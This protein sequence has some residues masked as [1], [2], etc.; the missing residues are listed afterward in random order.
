[1]LKQTGGFGKFLLVL[2][3][4]SGL[5]NVVGSIYALALNCQNIFHL[6]CIRI[7]RV[8]YTIAITAILIPVAF[9]VAANFMVSLSNFI[10]IIGI[11]SAAWAAVMAMEHLVI[12]KGNFENYE[13]GDWDIP[14]ALPTGLAAVGAALLSFG[15]AI[16]CMDKA[17]FVGPIAKQSGD[18]GVE[19]ALLLTAVFY[20]PLRMLEIRIRGRM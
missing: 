13:V 14:R 12:R 8:I 9:E 5:A 3:A 6:A 19:V 7:P 20:V 15:L 10:G 2:L 4:L 18:L 16:P 11:W 1:M 17:W